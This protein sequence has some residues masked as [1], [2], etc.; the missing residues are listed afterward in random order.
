MV[1]L[2]LSSTLSGQNTFTLTNIVPAENPSDAVRYDQLT[3]LMQEFN[4]EAASREAA[5]KDLEAR[6]DAIIPGLTEE[7][8]RAIARSIRLDEFASPNGALNLNSKRISNLAPAQELDE[9][10]TYGQLLDVLTGRTR[11]ISA[12]AMFRGTLTQLQQTIVNQ[13]QT[14]D[15]AVLVDNVEIWVDEGQKILL[16]NPAASGESGIYSLVTYGNDGLMRFSRAAGFTRVEDFPLATTIF[17]DRGSEFGN[18]FWVVADDPSEEAPSDGEVGIGISLIP[19]GRASELTAEGVMHLVNGTIQL[20]FDPESF[21][22]VN[23]E[24]RLSESVVSQIAQVAHLV[25]DLGAL[26]GRVQAAEET[27]ATHSSGIADL[28]A[29]VADIQGNIEQLQTDLTSAEQL[30]ATQTGLISS[31]QS[32]D[33]SQAM[34]IASLEAENDVLTALVQQLESRLRTITINF[35]GETNDVTPSTHPG[36][37]I[38][39]NSNQGYYEISHDLAR[40]VKAHLRRVEQSGMYTESLVATLF[41]IA[42]PSNN[43]Y[44]PVP[45]TGS[46]QLIL[47]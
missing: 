3:A 46:H 1:Y 27:I 17:V 19:W 29:D 2:P 7:Q 36:V 33:T 14:S 4:N 37:S 32:S 47:S 21:Q 28:Q 18:S 43:V 13:Q 8:V 15:G 23:G 41:P 30:N 12:T 9:A 20:F 45:R 40:P 10:A 31:L 24:L 22:N 44:I 34:A 11:Q 35:N 25:T 38:A 42:S 6:L 16:V 5:D 26:T 39:W